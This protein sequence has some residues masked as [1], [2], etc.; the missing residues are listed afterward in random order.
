M[1]VRA[2]VQKRQCVGQPGRVVAAG[3]V[4][5]GP[6]FLFFFPYFRCGSISNRLYKL[7]LRGMLISDRL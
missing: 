1:M 7:I 2:V 6:A 4:V 5:H 3:A